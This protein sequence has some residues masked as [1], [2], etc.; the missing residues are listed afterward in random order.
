[1]KF[2]FTFVIAIAFATAFAQDH[3]AKKESASKSHAKAGACCAKNK[4]AMTHAKVGSCK[5]E[6]KAISHAK[7]GTHCSNDKGE[8]THANVASCKVE[9]KAVAHAKAGTCASEAK[10][11]SKC[12]GDKMSADAE[13]MQEAERMGMNAQGKESC[14]KSTPVKPM[15]KGDKG[16]CNEIGIQAKFKFFVAGEGY[17]FFG[18]DD[19]AAKSRKALIAKGIRVGSVQPVLAST[20]TIR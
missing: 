14:C 4:G 10:S 18:C 20:S 19:S 15:A 3:C 13:F 9:A 8:M 17:K 6:A 2:V 11:A 5:G 1:M 12:G 16:C 7:A